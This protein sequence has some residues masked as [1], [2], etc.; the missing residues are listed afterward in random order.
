MTNGVTSWERP[1]E[2]TRLRRLVPIRDRTRFPSTILSLIVSCPVPCSCQARLSPFCTEQYSRAR[3]F[4]ACLSASSPVASVAPLSCTRAA[5]GCSV[6]AL[7]DETENSKALLSPL[8]ASEDFAPKTLRLAPVEPKAGF[9]APS[10]ALSP[11]PADA[12]SASS[13]LFF[14]APKPDTPLPKDPNPV[15]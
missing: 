5:F 15:E 4:S 8:S 13:A 2:T 3:N 7:P 1:N 11:V 12:V 10:F 9:V 14:R 6:A